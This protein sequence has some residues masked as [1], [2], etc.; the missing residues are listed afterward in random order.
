MQGQQTDN[1]MERARLVGKYEDVIKKLKEKASKI[2]QLTSDDKLIAINS[3]DGAEHIKT[4]KKKISLIS[5]STQLTTKKLIEAGC[6]TSSSSGILTWMQLRSDEKRE[7]LFPML[8]DLYKEKEM[9]KKKMS[10]VT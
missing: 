5:F 4:K 1:Q 10:S 2:V 7:V 3:F 6:T 8:C 9:L